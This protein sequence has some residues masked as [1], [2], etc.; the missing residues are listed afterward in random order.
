[1]VWPAPYF[2]SAVFFVSGQ[3]WQQVLEAK[4]SD[5]PGYY[6]LASQYIAAVLNFANGACQPQSVV[7]TLALASAWLAGNGPASCAAHGSC[8]AQKT[9]AAVLDDYNKRGSLPGQSRALR[10]RDAV[11]NETSWAPSAVRQERRTAA[12]YTNPLSRAY[13]VSAVRFLRCSFV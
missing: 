11:A 7:D 3:T 5:A 12:L 9:W 2:R 6:Q 10:R 4:V 8:A 1:V 13:S